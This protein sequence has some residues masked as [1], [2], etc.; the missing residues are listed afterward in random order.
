MLF[1]LLRALRVF[2]AKALLF[3]RNHF[4]SKIPELVNLLVGEIPYC[5]VRQERLPEKLRQPIVL[6]GKTGGNIESMLRLEYA[7]AIIG[8]T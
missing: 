3:R 4:L 8:D 6:I 2:V 1:R 7:L 5:V